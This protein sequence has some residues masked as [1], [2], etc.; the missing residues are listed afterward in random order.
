MLNVF[1]LL[2]G[3][4]VFSDL[5][6]SFLVHLVLSILKTLLFL[7]FCVLLDNVLVLGH[8]DHFLDLLLYF[9]TIHYVIVEFVILSF[10]LHLVLPAFDV[11]YANALLSDPY[12]F[13]QVTI[14]YV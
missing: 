4:V 7:I 3:L 12:L 2:K 10:V 6:D 8:L 9:L 5:L 13:L 11:V 14:F 1:L